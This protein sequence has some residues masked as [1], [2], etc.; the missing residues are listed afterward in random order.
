MA[1]GPARRL[2]SLSASRVESPPGVGPLSS[3]VRTNSVTTENASTAFKRPTLDGVGVL[4]IALFFIDALLL[5]QGVLS[6]LV[7]AWLILVSLPRIY[8]SKSLTGRGTRLAH[9]AML[10]AAALLVFAANWINNRIART[11]AET[12][13]VAVKKFKQ[14]TGHYP[15]NLQD[16]V[17]NFIDHIPLAKYTIAFNDFKFSSNE[18]HVSLWYVEMPPFGRP[19]FNFKC[20][21]WEYL[22]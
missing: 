11:R 21:R 15:A 2:L 14:S 7:C 10:V 19:A 13:I 1:L 20:D 6:A 5:N 9:I 16:L 3:I 8:L 12:L 22:D 18:A 17:P 4:A